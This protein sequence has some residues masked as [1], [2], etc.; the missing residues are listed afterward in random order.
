TDVSL[1]VG[2]GAASV[3][4]GSLDFGPVA[5][6]SV[7]GPR[8]VTLTNRGGSAFRVGAVLITGQDQNSFV[9]GANGCSQPGGLPFALV[10]GGRCTVQVSFR[11]TGPGT[12]TGL[13]S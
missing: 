7:E 1:V 9:L 13:L 12:R 8:T 2:F 11:P 10:P 6:G 3:A 4:P 5:L